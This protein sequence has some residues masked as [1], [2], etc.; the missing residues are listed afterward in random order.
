MAGL[1]PEP[2]R[3]VRAPRVAASGTSHR[4]ARSES[5]ASAVGVGI[6]DGFDIQREPIVLREWLA[7]VRGCLEREAATR[8]LAVD[9]RC[10]RGLPDDLRADPGWLGGLL[11]AMGREA[12]DATAADK[13]SLEVLE[14]A[15]D[16]LR[17]ELDAAGSS[18]AP[19]AGMR[20]IATS[21]GGHLESGDAGR[22][23]LVLPE[24]LA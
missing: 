17:F 24:A 13:V 20:Q 10:E 6:A 18:L 14:G 3:V 8:G 1:T 5:T 23:T 12:L 4:G 15:D 2:S 16:A 19:V 22:L 21:L 11:V 9:L 7:D